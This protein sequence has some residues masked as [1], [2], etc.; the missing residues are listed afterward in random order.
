MNKKTKNKEPIRHHYIPKF[1]IR[2]FSPRKDD[3]V[4]YYDIK[5][6][7]YFNKSIDEVF[8]HHNL[9]RDEE[10]NPD[11]P[12]QIESDL[13]KYECEIAKIIKAIQF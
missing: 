6:K 11:N 3:F 8:M 13:A 2:N 10:N 9:Y 4:P 7:D 12:T 1:I 5:R